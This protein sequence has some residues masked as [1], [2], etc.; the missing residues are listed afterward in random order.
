MKLV[1]F[2]Q[3]AVRVKDLENPPHTW[4][5]SGYEPDMTCTV[6]LLC[7]NL[8]SNNNFHITICT[9]RCTPSVVNVE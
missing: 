9:K 5:K 2:T 6:S 8:R 3:Y 4:K 1:P 7:K